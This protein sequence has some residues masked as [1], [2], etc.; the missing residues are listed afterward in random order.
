[1]SHGTEHHL[2]HAEHAQ[3]PPHDPFDRRVAMTMTIMAAL[4]AGA[5]LLS[6]NAHTET[7]R[8]ATAADTFHTQAADFYNFYQAKNIR[9]NEFQAFLLMEQLLSKDGVRQDD[10]AKALRTHWINKVNKYEGAGYWEKFNTALLSK[11][12]PPEDG[13]GELKE[14]KA[15]ADNFTEQA[16]EAEHRSHQVHGLATWIDLGHLGLE[17]GLVLCAVA[18]LTKQRPFWL[19]GICFGV[20]AAI[21]AGY[22]GVAWLTL[23]GGAH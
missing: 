23:G 2:E 11:S 7:L 22:G 8:L 3:H 10:D 6:H 14:L 20:V 16:K 5:T 12:K 1:M 15:K 18:V 9:S 17:L 13:Q 19:A 4:L 21:L